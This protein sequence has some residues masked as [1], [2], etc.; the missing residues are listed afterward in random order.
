MPA[1]LTLV[2]SAIPLAIAALLF[3]T[4]G[5]PPGLAPL[6]ALSVAI[7]SALPV[8]LVGRIDPSRAGGRALW[9]W[10]AVGG[11]TIEAS[12][13]IDALAAVSVALVLAYTGAALA[14][15]SRVQPRHPALAAL[16]LGVGLLAVVVVVTD[17]LVA[18]T[19]ALSALAAL[20]VLGSLAVAPQGATARAAAYLSIGMQAWILCALLLSR[21]GSPTFDLGALPAIAITSGALAAGTIGALLCAGLYP[22]VP[23][24]VEE[25]DARSDPG[26]VGSLL[27]MP[28]GIA[29]SLVLVRLMAAAGA[30]P[31]LLSLPQPPDEWRFGAVLVVLAAVALTIARTAVDPRRPIAVGVALV[32]LTAALPELR[33]PHAVLIAAILTAAYAGVVSLALPERWE[34]IRSD[35]GMVALWVG[36]ASGSDLAVAAGIL[37]LLVRASQ[38]LAGSFWLPPHRDYLV[39]IAGS[40][41]FVASAVAM[42]AGAVSAGD[43][44]VAAL[45]I[46]AA[47]LLVVLE[48][49]QV[50]RRFRAADVPADLDVASGTVAFLLAALGAVLLAPLGEIVR[51]HV[52]YA[53][54]VTQLHLAGVVVASTVA[55]TL[56]RGLRR[57]LP[58]LERVAERS[59]PAMRALDPVPVAVGSFRALEAAAST[60]AAVF[61]AFERRAGAWLAAALIVAILAWA[62]R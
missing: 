61:G 59:S 32:V 29:A 14:H 26:P 19:V 13:R 54:P 9:E 30:G 7:A 51:P 60:G 33:W 11:P 15:G 31:S 48:L 45:A 25:G 27:L 36:I 62:V 39:L 55:V 5:R 40:T 1:E 2:L 38:A 6:G 58:V 24:S 16:T 18:A 44:I 56:A 42:G 37:A 47:A 46:A 52:A 49:A 12:Y 8:L 43:P 34:P 10:S 17:D 20:T 35:L 21:N 23:W 4:P 41:L 28:A 53:Q 3:F 22:A 57:M 50:A